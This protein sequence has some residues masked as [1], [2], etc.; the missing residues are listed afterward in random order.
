MA[1]GDSDSASTGLIAVYVTVPTPEVG[2]EIAQ[3]LLAER[4]VAC[5]NVFPPGVSFFRWEGAVQK[6]EETALLAKTRASLFSAVE[7][8]VVSAHPYDTPC[9]TAWPLTHVS[10]T[11]GQWV[12]DET[13]SDEG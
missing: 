4:L 7:A 8:C 6:E 13:A 9:I 2:E 10:Q 1:S 11:Y 12:L 3:G 5:V